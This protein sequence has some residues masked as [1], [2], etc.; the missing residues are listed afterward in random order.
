M[1]FFA[2]ITMLHFYEILGWWR[3]SADTNQVYFAEWNKCKPRAEMCELSVF[4]PSLLTT[5]FRLAITS[6]HHSST[7]PDYGHGKL[8]S[9]TSEHLLSVAVHH[10]LRMESREVDQLWVDRFLAQ[11]SDI[12]Y[13]I[14]LVL[15]W[16][17][18]CHPHARPHSFGVN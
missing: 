4:G 16:F 12:H 7:R 8:V 13:F 18:T 3:L 10:L 15:L 17:V 5:H 11:H 14:V 6:H 2:Y 1:P 9:F